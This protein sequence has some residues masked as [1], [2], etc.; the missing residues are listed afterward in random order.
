MKKKKKNTQY[1]LSYF[2]QHY[3]IDASHCFHSSQVSEEQF[4]ELR[5]CWRQN[6]CNSLFI[7][8]IL[9]HCWN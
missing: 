3:Q 8:L 4:K 5:V 2:L 1:F 7:G 9:S 6:V